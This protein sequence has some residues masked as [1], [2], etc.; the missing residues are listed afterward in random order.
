MQATIDSD[1]G[2]V[3][4]EIWA[5]ASLFFRHMLTRLWQK[6]DEANTDS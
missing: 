3:K 4:D 6:G 5:Q 2:N 1:A